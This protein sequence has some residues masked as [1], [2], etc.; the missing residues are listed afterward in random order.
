MNTRMDPAAVA[1]EARAEPL[2]S[3][4]L[5]IS[6]GFNP[7]FSGQCRPD[8]GPGRRR[9]V[10]GRLLWMGRPKRLSRVIVEW[11]RNG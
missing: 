3:V 7:T 2:D 8:V 10:E 9:R 5:P 11:R 1:D 4:W 6:G